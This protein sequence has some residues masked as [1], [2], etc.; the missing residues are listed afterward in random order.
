MHLTP[1]LLSNLVGMD[2]KGLCKNWP[3]GAEVSCHFEQRYSRGKHR[4]WGPLGWE[5]QTLII[6]E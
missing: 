2:V 4:D 3:L 6:R 5:A 1:G